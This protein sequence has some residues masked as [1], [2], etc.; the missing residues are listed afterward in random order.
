MTRK[1]EVDRKS[2]NLKASF[3]LLLLFYWFVGEVSRFVIVISGFVIVISKFVIV[4][5][6]FVIVI[7]KKISN[8]TSW[9]TNYFT[10]N[11]RV[12]GIGMAHCLYL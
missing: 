2:I 1:N 5:S 10:T 12:K 7:C 3:A 11:Q 4:I 8:Y 6:G 9:I